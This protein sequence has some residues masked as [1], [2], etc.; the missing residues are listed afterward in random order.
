MS[1]KSLCFATEYYEGDMLAVVLLLFPECPEQG[2]DGLQ[3]THRN[4]R[5]LPCGQS[6]VCD[7]KRKIWHQFVIIAIEDI[8]IDY[9][10]GTP[11]FVPILPISHEIHYVEF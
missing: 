11:S 3:H 2:S 7:G 5:A 1:N 4:H 10:R 9:V 8:T 6:L